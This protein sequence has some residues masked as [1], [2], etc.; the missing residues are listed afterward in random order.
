MYLRHLH[1]RNMKLLR[2]F[3]LSFGQGSDG[4]PRLWTV[5]IGENGTGKTSLLQAIALSAA[6]AAQVNGLARPVIGH[7]R[8]R[9]DEARQAPLEI[10]ATFDFTTDHPPYPGDPRHPLLSGYAALNLHRLKVISKITLQPNEVNLAASSTYDLSKVWAEDQPHPSGDP[11]D[12]ARS[13]Q[14]PGWFVAAYGVSRAL[15][16]VGHRPQLVQPAI[17][18]LSPLFDSRAGLTSTS[19]ATHFA[20]TRDS[21]TAR[22]YHRALKAALTNVQDLLPSIEDIELGGRGGVTKSGQLLERDRFLQR[23][24]QRQEK[25]PAVALSHGY[26]S[27]I[28]W[29]ADLVGH[30]FLEQSPA[31][32]PEALEG[33]VLID[34]IDLYLHPT[35]QVV[36]VRALRATF[37]RLQF[38]ATTHSPLILAGLTPEEVVRLGFDD[39]GNVVRIVDDDDPRLMTGSEILR[40][41]FGLPSAF[42]NTD[43][44]L[45]KLREYSMLAMN[46]YRSAEEDREMRELAAELQ[47]KGLR[48]HPY[49]VPRH[50]S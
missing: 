24:G 45:G 33:I 4:Y 17:E 42:P 26:Q 31:V 48:P 28:A 14:L 49:P 9:R 12:R 23:I 11:L 50:Q 34:E 32:E 44:E 40:S 30:F 43:P 7:L 38:I 19:F 46:P 27:T 29:I 2:D 36:L 41:Y 37:P 6:G 13:L 35:W 18:R 10:E 8:D 25:I 22:A 16:D 21:N 1:V 47:G 5:I 15:P 20:D 3:S 39:A